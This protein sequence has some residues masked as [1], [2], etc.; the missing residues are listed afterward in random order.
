[1]AGR[2]DAIFLDGAAEKRRGLQAKRTW[3]AFGRRLTDAWRRL[4]HGLLVTWRG[5]TVGRPFRYSP[6]H[7]PRRFHARPPRFFPLLLPFWR[8]AFAPLTPCAV[9]WRL[10]CGKGASQ[11]G[12]GAYACWARTVLKVQAPLFILPCRMSSATSRGPLGAP[13]LP[14]PALSLRILL[15]EPSSR[16]AAMPG[17]ALTSRRRALLPARR[18]RSNMLTCRNCM[19]CALGTGLLHQ[20]AFLAPFRYGRLHFVGGASDHCR[21][22][23]AAA[24]G[25]PC[26]CAC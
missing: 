4:R 1:V 22:L 10:D 17:I 23:R 2:V 20:R 12:A 8:G 14:P 15:H 25:C 7:R 19:L 18:A 24:A 26:L 21:Q 6:L 11:A 9:A 13:S 5:R 3:T 16:L